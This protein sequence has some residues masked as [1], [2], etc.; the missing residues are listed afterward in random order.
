MNV[1]KRKPKC[2]AIVTEFN[3]NTEVSPVNN[4]GASMEMPHQRERTCGPGLPEALPQRK[5]PMR[6]N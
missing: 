3:S 2:N 5:R 1:L 6:I 4:H